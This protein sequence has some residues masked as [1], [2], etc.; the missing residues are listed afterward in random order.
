MGQVLVDRRRLRYPG[1]TAVAG[2]R[3]A[4]ER[5]ITV[6]QHTQRQQRAQTSEPHTST[7]AVTHIRLDAPNA[8][9]LTALDAL[10]EASRALTQAYV[11]LFCTDEEPNGFRPPAA[12]ARTARS[13][14]WQRVA[15]QQAAGSATTWRTNRASADQAYQ[16]ALAE[17]KRH[18]AN[19][20]LKAG[21]QEPVWHEWNIPTLRRPCIQANANVVRLEEASHSSFDY[22]LKVATLEKGH[23]LLIPVKLADYHKAPLTDPATGNRRTVKR[24]VTLNR[25]DGVGWLTLSYDETV[26]VHP[27][28]DAPVIGILACWP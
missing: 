11:T 12:S 7:Q 14:R 15:I 28:S 13:E 25:R 27:A 21:A 10:A 19:G 3:R 23:P 16:E 22:W 17:Y 1:A 20:T 5:T 18:Q 2:A 9:K 4:A 8:G 26:I 24:S 6:K